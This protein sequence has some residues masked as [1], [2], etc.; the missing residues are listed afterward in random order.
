[1]SIDDD[2]FDVGDAV[3]KVKGAS[4]AFERITERFNFYE[5]Q[6]S[7]MV[8]VLNKLGETRKLLN[9]LAEEFSDGDPT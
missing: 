2:F 6:H 4:K 8:E 3:K 9:K 5:S 7:D 1:M